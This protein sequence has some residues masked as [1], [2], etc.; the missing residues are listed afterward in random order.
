MVVE[1]AIFGGDGCDETD[2]LGTGAVYDTTLG[3]GAGSVTTTV[4]CGSNYD[5]NVV[6]G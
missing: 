6:V 1:C 2:T 4:Y 3:A 5:I